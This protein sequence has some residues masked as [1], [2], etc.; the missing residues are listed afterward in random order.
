[1]GHSMGGHGALTIGFKNPDKY[2]SISAFAPIC[3]PSIV[4]WGT[5]AFSNYLGDD[6]EAWKEYDAVELLKAN[7]YNKPVLVDVGI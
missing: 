4:P 2:R 6:K 1:M 7:T 3:N 5:K